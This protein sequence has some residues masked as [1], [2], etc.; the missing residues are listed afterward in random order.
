[1]S[2]PRRRKP[3]ER[4]SARKRRT[5]QR[6]FWGTETEDD[7]YIETIRPADDPTVMLRSLSSPPLPGRETVAVH[8]FAAVAQKAASLA[9]ALAAASDLLDMDDDPEEDLATAY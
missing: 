5:P 3:A 1:M 4:P 8:Y 2:S 6:D 9:I 7:E